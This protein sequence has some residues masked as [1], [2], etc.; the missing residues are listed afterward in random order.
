MINLESTHS[1]EL[2]SAHKVHALLNQLLLTGT[3]TAAPKTHESTTETRERR[4]VG[5]TITELTKQKVRKLLGGERPEPDKLLIQTEVTQAPELE[6]TIPALELIIFFECTP[7]T[8]LNPFYKSIA[9]AVN[10][11]QPTRVENATV[12]VFAVHSRLDQLRLDPE[13]VQQLTLIKGSTRTLGQV[14]LTAPKPDPIQEPNWYEQNTSIYQPMW[15][16][17]NH[18]KKTNSLVIP[19]LIIANHSTWSTLQKEQDSMPQAPVVL[20]ICNSSKNTCEQTKL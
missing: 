16:L 2:I 18:A 20:G 10:S 6:P 4:T 5:Q 17:I 1:P 11:W 14:E 12:S 7:F 13:P 3:T 19:L 9:A 8:K 15:E